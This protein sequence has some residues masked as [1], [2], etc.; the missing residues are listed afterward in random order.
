MRTGAM[1]LQQ[2]I[3]QVISRIR[4]RSGRQINEQSTRASLVDPVL[5]ALAWDL[6][7]LD[8]VD[9]EYSPRRATKAVDYAMLLNG[10][11]RMLV[12]TKALGDSI[13]DRWWANRVVN[14]AGSAGADWTVLTN[15]DEYRIYN[16]AARLPL[17]QK[18]FCTVSLS[19]QGVS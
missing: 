10:A 5:R 17:A 19:D 9:R 6:E 14:V 4:Q 2:V 18:L 16:A 15:G 7:D 12:A 1:E 3:S 11:P 13:G 8:E